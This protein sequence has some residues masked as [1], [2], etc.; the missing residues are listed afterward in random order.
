MRLALGFGVLMLLMV[1][2]LIVGFSALSD[3]N[4]NAA[5]TINDTYPKVALVQ[6]TSYIAL[7]TNRQTRNL[8]INT[9]HQKLLRYKDTLAGDFAK[10]SANLD[11]L[12]HMLS[13]DK[14]REL[15][16]KIKSTQTD[17]ESYINGVA[18]VAMTNDKEA[19]VAALYTEKYKTQAVYF[20]AL[21]AM[22][23]LQ[24]QT[25]K[26]GGEH[27]NAV[28]HRGVTLMTILGIIA[29]LAGASVSWLMT[30]K[31]LKQL[32]GEPD[33][34]V[35]ITEQIAQG[36]LSIGIDL[37]SDDKVSLLYALRSMRDRLAHI[38]GDVREGTEAITSAS[39][40]IAAGNLDLSA[41]TESQA[42]SLEETAASMEQLTATV[43]QN[44]ENSRQANQMAASAS[45]VAMKGGTVVSQ[46]VETMSSI[47]D[48]SKKIVDIIGV[49]DSI[50]FQTNILA[51]NAA[52]EAARAGE[53]GRGFAVVATEVRNLAQRSAAAAKEIKALIGDS[54]EK[55]AAGTRL[56]DNAGNTM[57]EV[58]ASVKRVS[59][60]IAE[61]TSA[62]Q[63][64]TAGI[65][66]V[67]V[68]IIEMD[69]V[70][71]Q[72]SALVEEAAAAAASLQDQA[73]KLSELVSVFKLSNEK[74]QPVPQQPIVTGIA[75][76][77]SYL[78]LQN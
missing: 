40:Q 55:V 61:I 37:Q 59:D 43:K 53:Q 69:N 26:A 7:D 78:P 19:A 1:F 3:Q 27:T 28:Y 63:E 15:F 56:V 20:D 46:V 36:D 35:S 39:G 75:A 67:N 11:R 21:T 42:S 31:L 29:L 38:V 58:V 60:I 57:N 62:S 77:R 74:N 13:T 2:I 72:N 12:D 71:Q 23:D 33:Y 24:E 70:T 51:L 32:G 65:G 22:V 49:I 10:I 4:N 54:V 25:M 8:I 68:A 44:A 76:Y 50:A 30:K 16:N 73:N 34:A 47:N 66:Q 45:D 5:F 18:T 14:E 52:V 41:R 64:Q 6:Q 9:D 48:S 17:F